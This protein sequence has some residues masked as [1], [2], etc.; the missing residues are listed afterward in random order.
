MACGLPRYLV[1]PNSGGGLI[2]IGELNRSAW[3]RGRNRIDGGSARRC[4]TTFADAQ[5][6]PEAHHKSSRA[7]NYPLPSALHLPQLS[8]LHASHRALQSFRVCPTR[9]CF[10][11]DT[12]PCRAGQP[13]REPPMAACQLQQRY[14]NGRMRR[15][16][17]LRL[18]RFPYAQFEATHGTETAIRE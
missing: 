10:S 5:R 4:P 8:K 1:P 15:L 14:P 7:G 9:S 18:W 13:M 12:W 2:A 17:H 6:D 11:R 16:L 3:W